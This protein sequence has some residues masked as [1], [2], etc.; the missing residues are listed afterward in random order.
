M[1]ISKEGINMTDRNESESVSA[2]VLVESDIA[3]V[4]DEPEA[5]ERSPADIAA[6]FANQFL[7]HRHRGV[8]NCDSYYVIFGNDGYATDQRSRKECADVWRRL[9]QHHDTE[10]GF[11][12][13]RMTWAI[14]LTDH[15]QSLFDEV[16]LDHLVWDTWMSVCDE[17][18]K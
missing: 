14:V 2:A 4:S 5:S 7:M 15:S 9:R 10:T 13:D 6:D 1:P 11:S 17:F 3:R 18:A 16:E 12:S 8:I